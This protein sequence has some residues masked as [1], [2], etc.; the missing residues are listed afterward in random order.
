MCDV[1]FH[2]EVHQA[3]L[4][5][6]GKGRFCY[7]TMGSL[8]MGLKGLRN[9]PL[10]LGAHKK[11]VRYVIVYC[12]LCNINVSDGAGLL[13]CFYFMVGETRNIGHRVV[14]VTLHHFN[15]GSCHWFSRT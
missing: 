7:E 15:L 5:F 9:L 11:E 6:R 3:S 1:P 2:K 4:F 10:L 13:C 14:D 12:T 8:G